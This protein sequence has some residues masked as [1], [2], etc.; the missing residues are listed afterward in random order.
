M[1]ICC[2]IS[3]LWFPSFYACIFI[4]RNVSLLDF[5]ISIQILKPGTMVL[6][7]SSARDERKGGKLQQRWLGPYVIAEFVG[8]GVHKITS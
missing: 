6:L 1:C 5:I 3:N 2:N 8:E 4:C 7:R